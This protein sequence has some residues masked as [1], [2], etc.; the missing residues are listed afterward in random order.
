MEHLLFLV[1]R[2]PYPPNKGDKI[3]SFHLL[4]HL[5]QHYRVHLGTF[6]DDPADWQ[7]CD[8][9]R[10]LCHASHSRTCVRPWRAPAA[11]AHSLAAGR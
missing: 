7:H 4:K 6:V 2:I 5:A 3:R 9:V 11:S 1:H 8:E 10:K